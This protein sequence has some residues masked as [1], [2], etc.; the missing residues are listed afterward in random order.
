MP[1]EIE[2]VPADLYYWCMASVGWKAAIGPHDLCG[3]GGG[4]PG[5]AIATAALYM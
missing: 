4:G 2:L 1:R 5:V 3:G